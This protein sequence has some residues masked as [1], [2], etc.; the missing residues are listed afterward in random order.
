LIYDVAGEVLAA[1]IFLG[2]GYVVGA[3]WPYVWNYIN[4]LPGV[5]TGAAAGTLL[6]AF[7]A[8]KWVDNHRQ[9]VQRLN[10]KG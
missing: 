4:G 2:A 5:L 10:A 1:T 7:G 6:L 8:K 9:R 3:D